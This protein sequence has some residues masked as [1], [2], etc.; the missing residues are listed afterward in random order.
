MTRTESKRIEGKG[1]FVDY[2]EH[3]MLQGFRGKAH[4]LR[5]KIHLGGSASQ[6]EG[7]VERHDGV[8]WHEVATISGPALSVDPKAGYGILTES[9]FRPDR[10]RLVKLAEEVL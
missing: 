6:S 4:T 9:T 2:I 8:K 1:Q 10:D 5:V 7:R 3:V